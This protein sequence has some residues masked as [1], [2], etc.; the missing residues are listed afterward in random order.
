MRPLLRQVQMEPTRMLINDETFPTSSGT[1][2]QFSPTNTTNPLIPF[3]SLTGDGNNST[4]DTESTA[5]KHMSVLSLVVSVASV[6]FLFCCAFPRSTPE[7]RM[8]REAMIRR[9]RERQA[10]RRSNEQERSR[11]EDSQYREEVVGKSLWIQKVI[12]EEGEQLTLGPADVSSGAS[13]GG[14]SEQSDNHSMG[15]D[16]Y[17][18][19]ASTC[20][21]CLEP[22]R[23]GDV[24]AWSRAPP[25]FTI[26][27]PLPS[28]SPSSS[29]STSDVEGGGP[30]QRA[31][32]PPVRTAVTPST[33]AALNDVCKHV[34]H[35]DCIYSW[36]LN[37]KHDDCPACRVTI[38]R[39]P[40]RKRGKNNSNNDSRDEM[41]S[42]FADCGSD[43]DEDNDLLDEEEGGL[44]SMAFVVVHGLVSRVQRVSYSLIGSCVNTAEEHQ[45]YDEDA[46]DELFDDEHGSGSAQVEMLPQQPS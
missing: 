9:R 43:D 42:D 34:F 15:S 41:D 12:K 30:P 1:D 46:D 6:M 7:G 21:I 16:G 27:I 33:G 18:E 5:S 2:S 35:R 44:S 45:R 20:I 36:L 32:M 37:P 13:V 11:M 39:E 4:L 31:P 14:A 19:E 3:P 26:A 29:P 25:Q 10:Q 22:F 17:R 8:H 38:V 23:V 24:V 40:P 28:P